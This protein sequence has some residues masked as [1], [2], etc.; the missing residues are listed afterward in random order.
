MLIIFFYCLLGIVFIVVA[1]S[2]FNYNASHCFRKICRI[3]VPITILVLVVCLF[4]VTYFLKM[5]NNR[6][7]DVILSSIN[8]HS[9]SNRIYKDNLEKAL[10]LDSLRY[11]YQKID[12]I[13]HKDS[14]YSYLIGENT[15]MKRILS[16]TKDA[17]NE[18]IKRYGR[19]ND[20]LSKEFFY[21]KE[22]LDPQNIVLVKPNTLELKNLNIALRLKQDD[23]KPLALHIQIIN[24]NIKSNTPIILYT[25]YY[26]Y[27]S[28]INSFIIPNYK[29]QDVIVKL[30]YLI[31]QNDTTIYKYI[32]YDGNDSAGDE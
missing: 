22:E 24:I 2:L 30:G 25:Q 26:Q 32:V 8:I 15:Q 11:Y 29:D 23:I 13:A 28:G 31:L 9:Y 4:I 6:N 19:L 1:W 3:I 12:S 14:V 27:H 18:Q 16:T 10:I 5:Q 17:L 21:C 7:L 20:Y